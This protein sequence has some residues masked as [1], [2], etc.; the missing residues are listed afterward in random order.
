MNREEEI[1]RCEREIAEIGNRPG[2]DQAYLT[3]LGA[4][5]WEHEKRLLLS[6][7]KQE[8]PPPCESGPGN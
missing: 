7:R 3:V 4:Q 8:G 2:P 5:D 1:A 6:S